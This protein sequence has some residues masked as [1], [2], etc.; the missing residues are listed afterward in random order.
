MR[1]SSR[2]QA[3]AELVRRTKWSVPKT[4]YPP[5]SDRLPGSRKWRSI[6]K[7]ALTMRDLEVVWI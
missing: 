6:E 4:H 2:R 3:P 7:D 1:R 5:P